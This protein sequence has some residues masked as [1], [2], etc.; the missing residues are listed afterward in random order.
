M[1]ERPSRPWRWS[2][3]ACDDQHCVHIGQHWN[4]I[5]VNH[6]VILTR[7]NRRQLC[8][9]M[10]DQLSHATSTFFGHHV[11]LIQEEK[12]GILVPGVRIE[13][14]G[15]C[16][17]LGI[18]FLH[19]LAWTYGVRGTGQQACFTGTAARCIPSSINIPCSHMHVHQPSPF[20]FLPRNRTHHR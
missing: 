8:E 9:A 20:S 4:G 5:D 10:C 12:V 2:P 14:G 18:S 17:I 13:F 19:D 11:R 7:R 1:L 16:C 6:A 3:R 15:C